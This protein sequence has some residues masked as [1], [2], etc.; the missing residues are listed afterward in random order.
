MLFKPPVT[1][2]VIILVILS[3]PT[4]ALSGPWCYKKLPRAI[5]DVLRWAMGALI[6]LCGYLLICQELIIAVLVATVLII[7]WRFYL[8]A[9]LK[10]RFH[11]CDGCEEL[12]DKGV[13]SGCRLQANGVRRY[14]EIA[15]QLYLAS[16]QVP[17]ICRKSKKLCFQAKNNISMTNS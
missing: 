8:K 13:C 9:R 4:L 12:S 10:R 6:A 3:I 2:A 17:E 11:A 7:F 15:T 14:E 16:S 1:R 5:R